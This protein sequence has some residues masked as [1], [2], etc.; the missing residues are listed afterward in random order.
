VPNANAGTPTTILAQTKYVT[1]TSTAAV[2]QFSTHV[3]IDV[4]TGIQIVG[5]WLTV[6]GSGNL[7]VDTN[8]RGKKAIKM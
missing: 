7:K 4:S 1:T 6:D 5:S 2:C 3:I 8:F